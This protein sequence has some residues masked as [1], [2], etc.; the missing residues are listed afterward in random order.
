[1]QNPFFN[2]ALKQ[3]ARLL[4][5]P[6][7]VALILAELAVKVSRVDWSTEGRSNLKA[8]ISLMGRL[9]KANLTG[10]YK[11]KSTRVLVGLLAAC[12]YFINPF[13][14]VPDLL[15]GIGLVDD[16]A[17][18]AWVFSSAATEL[19]AFEE[20]EKVTSASL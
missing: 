15:V 13:D 19:K 4:G 2:K 14:L 7:R 1:M 5:K 20:W 3:A 17:I 12:I 11:L 6:C 8:R 18:I 16:M 9:I 10:T